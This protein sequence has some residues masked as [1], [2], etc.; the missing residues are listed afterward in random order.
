MNTSARNHHRPRAVS[1][2]ELERFIDGALTPE[3]TGRIERA[4]AGSPVDAARVA[5]L[6][7]ADERVRAALLAPL[8]SAS[9]RG[10]ARSGVPGRVRLSLA[11]AA[12]VLIAGVVAAVRTGWVAADSPGPS[13]APGIVHVEPPAPYESVRVVFSIPTIRRERTANQEHE[14]A[15]EKPGEASQPP[16]AGAR[17]I[18]SVFGDASDAGIRR[19]V[20]AINEASPD[21]RA[22]ALAALGQ[23]LRSGSTAVRILDKLEPRDQ[24]AVCSELA[25]DAGLRAVALQRLRDL[26]ENPAVGPDAWAA[27]RA[28]AGAPGMKAWL[29]SYGLLEPASG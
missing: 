15:V 6:R 27:A 7:S 14:G 4:V 10:A 23:T 25:L 19:T 5:A 9:G 3:H 8:A 16:S 2:A 11:A 22:A 17:A 20:N 1:D 26:T 13:D 29:R 24:V 28:L 21:D 12:L 18:A